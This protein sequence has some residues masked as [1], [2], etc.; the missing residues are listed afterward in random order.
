MGIAVKTSDTARSSGVIAEEFDEPTGLCGSASAHP[1]AMP[2]SAL[3]R[4]G[5]RRPATRATRG[6]NSTN[7][8]PQSPGCRVSDT[9]VAGGFIGGCDERSR[10][11]VP[12][13]ASG[14][15]PSSSGGILNIAPGALGCSILG[16]SMR[17]YLASG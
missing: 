9:I 16:C 7:H 10:P 6:A 14:C 8:S 5:P 11:E 1:P 15:A 13:P 17:I 3:I 2:S 4:F 12:F